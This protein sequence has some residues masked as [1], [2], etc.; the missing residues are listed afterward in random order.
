[1]LSGTNQ[2]GV[3]LTAFD[4]VTNEN[5]RQHFSIAETIGD[6]CLR[7]NVYCDATKQTLG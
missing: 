1:M 7:L 2:D 3:T 4:S 6:T 5:V